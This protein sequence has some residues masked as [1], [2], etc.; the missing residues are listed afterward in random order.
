M[1]T[2]VKALG[3]F[4]S[5]TFFFFLLLNILAVPVLISQAPQGSIWHFPNRLVTLWN[6]LFV[7]SIILASLRVHL[8]ISQNSKPL[9]PQ[10][11]FL[12]IGSLLL[13]SLL[14]GFPFIR[15][16]DSSLTKGTRRMATPNMIF[17]ASSKFI[18]IGSSQGRVQGPILIYT[19][20][21]KDPF[22]IYPEGVF[23]P[24]QNAL[25][26]LQTGENI[27][28]YDRISS[29]PP[30]MLSTLWTNIQHFTERL[31]PQH[32]LDWKAI[33]SIVS[34]VFLL[35]SLYALMHISRWLLFNSFLAFS[36]PFMSITGIAFL[37]AWVGIPYHEY[38]PA[39]VQ[40][41]IGVFCFTLQIFL[42]HSGKR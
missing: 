1:R 11:T 34:F 10:V 38:L 3:R 14:L 22:K 29:H 33:L 9:L 20:R 13:Y 8:F 6:V 35:V 2:T 12:V 19:P 7:P 28:L 21:Q 31:T 42:G 25:H 30:F 15:L 24:E 32:P 36:L 41:G 37:D 40:G 39:I 27:P 23:D 4:I 17:Y 5:S 18:W 16:P 26:I